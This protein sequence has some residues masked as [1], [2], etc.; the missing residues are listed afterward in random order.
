MA[1]VAEICEV[2]T[3]TSTLILAIAGH[4][5]DERVYTLMRVIEINIEIIYKI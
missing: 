3:R 5:I 1:W 4:V 2:Y